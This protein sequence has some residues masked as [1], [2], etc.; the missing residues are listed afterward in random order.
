MKI[1]YLPSSSTMVTA[2]SSVTPADV[3]DES[4]TREKFSLPST[5]LSLVIAI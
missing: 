2:A 3:E 5:M 4:I 1:D